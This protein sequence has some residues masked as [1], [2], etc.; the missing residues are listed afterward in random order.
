MPSQRPSASEALG[1]PFFKKL[2]GIDQGFQSQLKLKTLEEEKSQHFA[3]K[4]YSMG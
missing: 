1:H 3:L 4:D 2:N